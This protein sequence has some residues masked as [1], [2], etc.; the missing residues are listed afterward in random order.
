MYNEKKFVGAPPDFKIIELP[1]QPILNKGFN[2]SIKIW[3]K[4]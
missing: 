1:L 3:Q 4:T 2:T